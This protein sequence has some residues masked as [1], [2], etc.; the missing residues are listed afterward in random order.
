MSR[1]ALIEVNDWT[2]DQVEL[3]KKTYAKGCTDLELQLFLNVARRTGLDPF[4]RQIFAVSRWNA[5]EQRN[6]MAIQTSVDGYRLIAERTGL[7][8]GQLGPQWCGLDGVWKDVWLAAEA[9]AASRVGVLKKTFTEPLWGTARWSSYVQTVKSGE[10]NTM[11]SRM[12]DVMLAKCAESL[13]LR[14]AFPQEMS[15]IYTA[16]EMAQADSG[17]LT[18][19][20][21]AAVDAFERCRGL[22]AAGK[23][24][25]GAMMAQR[26]VKLSV[27]TMSEE[28]QVLADVT[29]WLDAWDS[30]RHA[31][32]AHDEIVIEAADEEPD[33]AP[34]YD[35]ME[36]PF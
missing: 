25:L 27:R 9:P 1:P 19:V 35:P 12:G 22:D 11:W 20:L 4:A 36:A 7:Y 2:T 34:G 14:K 33:T 18:A 3:I 30:V 28:P 29:R 8:T 5:K 10:P 31:E 15:G 16:E 23:E 13:A 32:L 17:A 26:G 6:E 21:D 24:T